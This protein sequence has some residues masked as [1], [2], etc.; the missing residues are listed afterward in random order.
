MGREKKKKKKGGDGDK[1][2][3]R[4]S[5]FIFLVDKVIGIG[6]LVCPRQTRPTQKWLTHHNGSFSPP[7]VACD[8]FFSFPRKSQI[9][10]KKLF[11]KN[12]KIKK[13]P[14]YHEIFM[15]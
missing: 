9:S 14:H 6:R 5:R 13:M 4:A 12:K 15:K 7:F 11:I 10:V 3:A 2:L 1:L 8:E